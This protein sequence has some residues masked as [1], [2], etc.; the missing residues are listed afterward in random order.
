MNTHMRKALALGLMLLGI[1]AIG[2]RAE[3]I[4]PNPD[5]MIVSVTPGNPQYGVYITSPIA[6]SG[7]DFQQVNLGAT[8]GS[9]LAIVVKSSGTVSEYFAMS[10]VDNGTNAWTALGADGTPALDQFELLGRFDNVS[11]P[12]DSAFSGANDIITGSIPGTGSGKYNQGAQTPA[13]NTQNLWLKL[14][15]PSSV[16]SPAARNLVLSIN[17]QLN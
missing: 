12:L 10:V 13:G 11:Q 7:Y 4:G 14:K 16:T 17:G 3:A 1:G 8:T 2:K 9:T 15:M 5:T 6:G